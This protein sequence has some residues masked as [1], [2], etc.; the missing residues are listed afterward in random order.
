M[1]PEP[2]TALRP[3]RQHFEQ[4]QAAHQFHHDVRPVLGLRRLADVVDRTD[5]RVI[6]RRGR[7][8]FALEAEQ[9]FFRGRKRRREELDGDVAPQLQIV[10]LV[11]LAH[12]A[13]AEGRDDFKAPDDLR[14]WG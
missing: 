8:R 5:V 1:R 7:A 4:R 11:H 6:E 12:A 3:G 2:V 9:V 10:R 14:P 13:R